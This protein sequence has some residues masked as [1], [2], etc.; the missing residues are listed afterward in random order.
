MKIYKYASIDNAIRIISDERLLLKNP[1]SFNDPFDS[2]VKR[3][4]KDVLEVNK[5][6]RSFT[7]LNMVMKLSIDPVVVNKVKI[8]PLFKTVKKQYRIMVSALKMNPR[9]KS[10]VGMS[11]LY[12]MF[13]IKSSVFKDEAES[14]IR[15][16]EEM[17]KNSVENTKKDALVTCFSKQHDSVLMWSHYGDSHSG[18]CIEYERPNNSEFVDVIYRKQRPTLKLA[19]L[20]SYMSA[21]TITG[22]KYGYLLDNK[23]ISTIVHPFVVKSNEWKYEKEVR[24]LT[25]KN[26][27]SPNKI[28]EGDKYY[29]K[30]PRPSKIYI[31]CRASGKKVSELIKLAKKKK[32]KYIFLK[33]DE[34]SFSLKNK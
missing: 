18:V 28:V 25:T 24:Y 14:E 7:S 26:S 8:N 22:E 19:E 13:G 16:F 15:R 23:L 34:N 20:V 17:A 11:A 4:K 5:I 27:L 12:K 30:M 2:D 33:T 31:G 6:M 10:D 9:F 32:I 21:I 29:Y 1:S 3:N